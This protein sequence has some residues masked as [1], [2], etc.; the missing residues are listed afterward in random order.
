[1]GTSLKHPVFCLKSKQSFAIPFLFL[2][3]SALLSVNV[4][5]MDRLLFV[6]HVIFEFTGI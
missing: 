2:V 4:I 6:C 3:I 5:K 1:M